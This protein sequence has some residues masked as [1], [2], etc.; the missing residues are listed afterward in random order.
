MTQKD[1]EKALNSQ[2]V[3]FKASHPI[4]VAY[5]AV[6]YTPVDGTPYLKV[7]FLHGETSQTTLGTE[8]KNRAPGVYQITVNIKGGQGTKDASTIIA[9]LKEYFKT[10]TRIIY[11]DTKVTITNF[12]LGNPQDEPDWYREIINIVFRSDI[13]N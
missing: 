2:L 3:L 6:S 5:P 7:D 4:D 8:S 1:V 11:E 13:V 12:Y 10:G 9:N